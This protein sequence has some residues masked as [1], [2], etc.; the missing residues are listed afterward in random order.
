MADIKENYYSDLG[1]ER[2]KVFLALR[3][4]PA[5]TAV[6][7]F[8]SQQAIQELIKISEGDMRKV[9]KEVLNDL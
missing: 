5:C 3:V 2:V 7:N 9:R 4:F 1:S 6:I 8:L